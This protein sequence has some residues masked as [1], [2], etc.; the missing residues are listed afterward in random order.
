MRSALLV[1][2]TALLMAPAAMFAQ[3]E[4]NTLL[5][6]MQEPTRNCPEVTLRVIVSTING[7]R[8]RGLGPENFLVAENQSPLE[9]SVNEITPGE[10]QIV[11]NSVV[12][13]LRVVINVGVSA[14]EGRG[15]VS[16]LT[17]SCALRITCGDLP[18]AIVNQPYKAQMHYT[19]P[20]GYFGPVIAISPV[21][22]VLRVN[23]DTGELTGQFPT[24]GNFNFT[25]S[26]TIIDSFSGP[27]TAQTGCQIRV[28]LA[29]ITFTDFSPKSATACTPGFP[30]VATGTGFQRPQGN[31]GSFIIFDNT[32]L[33]G[34]SLNA[35]GTQLTSPIPDELLRTFR[36]VNVG[37]S[38]R[39]AGISNIDSP[40]V[41]FTFRPTPVFAAN[42]TQTSLV[43]SGPS[44]G[45]TALNVDVLNLDSTTRLRISVGSTSRL[46]TASTVIGGRMVFDVP[47]DLIALGGSARISLVNADE[48]NPQGNEYQQSCAT[49][50]FRTLT[51]GPATAVISSLNPRTATACGPSFGLTVNGSNFASN[52]GVEWDGSALPNPQFG[53]GSIAVQVPDT[54][55]GTTGRTVQ[56]RVTTPGAATSSPE[57]FVVRNAPAV[58]RV[59]PTTFPLNGDSQVITIN[60]TGFVRGVT[61]IRWTPT[62][63][64]SVLLDA[65]QNPD[66]TT[67]I[68]PVPNRLLTSA[69]NVQITAVNADEAN[70]GGAAGTV[71]GA[72]P[73]GVTV[74]IANPPA[75]I[76]TLDPSSEIAART[77]PL[78]VTINGAGFINGAEVLVNGTVQSGVT[79]V[80]ESQ[81]H[82]T[83]SPAQLASPGTLQIGVRNPNA[84]L[85]TTSPFQVQAVP[86][87]RLTITANPAAPATVQ[88]I[89]LSLT[90][91]EASPRPLNATLSLTFEPNADNIPSSGLPAAALPVFAAGGSTFS[92]DVPAS[93]ALP[94]GSLVRPGTVSGTVIVRMTALT[95][96]GSGLNL[97][98]NPA[99][100]VRVVIPRTAPVIDSAK[101]L[102]NAAGFDLEILAYS[103][104]RNLTNAVVQVNTVAGTRIDGET[105][106]TVDLT[107]RFNDWFRDTANL[108]FGSQFKL[109][110]PFTLAN[111][112]ANAIDSVSVTLTNSVG[113]SSSV[114]GR[115]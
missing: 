93:G 52:S 4:E 107:S 74:S 5:V 112:D 103:P 60:G 86:V 101:I 82:F 10:Y 72:C 108:Q 85:S 106:F 100:E 96:A 45:T 91:S 76:R 40:L 56:V 89:T 48:A 49:N 8:L 25:A 53:N 27:F 24:P 36:T 12:T 78:T 38:T 84:A 42:F 79:F 43:A 32:V 81:L 11:Y 13:S 83:L 111:G 67:L 62:G 14:R 55:L 66:D 102:P 16:R 3:T 34:G 33:S 68:I 75:T 113:T 18:T 50:S 6:T 104:V 59:S 61:R 90:Q 94:A 110:I 87:G 41:R 88:D 9:V 1:L 65:G 105:R 31:V 47:N 97:L 77:T 19:V 39:A 71:G 28:D 114:T 26:I 20:D 92:F 70:P 54:R 29:P 7:T 64:T 95:V 44:T 30:I 58:T 2:S 35:A 99:P 51:L 37:V 57:A 69:G 109:R 21:S 73:A 15:F 63:G 46:L 80:S 17:T 22:N 115:R 23:P 98:P